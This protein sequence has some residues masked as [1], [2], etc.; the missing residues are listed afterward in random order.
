[1][2]NHE[3]RDLKHRFCWGSGPEPL[4]R[5]RLG[6][7]N[8]SESC[9]SGSKILLYTVRYRNILF[10]S[11]FWFQCY[12]LFF[13]PLF[14][15]TLAPPPPAFSRLTFVLVLLLVVFTL[16]REIVLEFFVLQ[17]RYLYFG[18]KTIFILPPRFPKIIFFLPLA[19]CHFR[20][21]F[22]PFCFN[23]NLFCI[24]L[25]FYSHFYFL[26]TLSSFFFYIFSPLL[27]LFHIFP[28]NDIGW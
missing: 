26:F 5:S 15:L 28:P 10:S 17:F 20:H 19:T 4:S 14:S 22:W 21:L 8:V 9:G 7:C 24:Y 12:S 25:P 2:R 3:E 18:P 6:L 16:P 13:S 27:I 23:S 11:K 1:M